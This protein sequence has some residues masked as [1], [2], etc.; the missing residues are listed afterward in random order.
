MPYIKYNNNRIQRRGLILIDQINEIIADYAASGYTL[1][2][3]QVF[4]PWPPVILLPVG[5]KGPY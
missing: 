1:T 4:T 2:L 3:R 5:F